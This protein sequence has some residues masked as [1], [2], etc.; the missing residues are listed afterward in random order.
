M[1]WSVAELC[2]KTVSILTLNCIW[3]NLFNPLKEHRAT[4][5][6]Y[7]SMKEIKDINCPIEANDGYVYD[8]FMLKQWLSLCAYNGKDACVI[9]SKLITEVYP[10]RVSKFLPDFNSKFPEWYIIVSLGMII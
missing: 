7:L 3:L 8:A 10:I 9:P 6:C 4:N 2:G 5:M 1:K